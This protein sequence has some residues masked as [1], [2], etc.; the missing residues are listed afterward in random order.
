MK[1]EISYLYYQW[2]ADAY[3]FIFIEYE[4]F[5]KLSLIINLLF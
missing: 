5:L 2:C 3:T 1:P 4:F